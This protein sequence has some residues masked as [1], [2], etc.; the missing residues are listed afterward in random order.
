[1]NDARSE[2][3]AAAVDWPMWLAVYS[4]LLPL[5]TTDREIFY[6]NIIIIIIKKY[7]NIK[8]QKKNKKIIGEDD[9]WL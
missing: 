8:K 2:R 3:S 9:G 7:K 6:N 5:T 1:M 4:I